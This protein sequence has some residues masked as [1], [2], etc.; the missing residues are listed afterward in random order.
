MFDLNWVNRMLECLFKIT[1]TSSVNILTKHQAVSKIKYLEETEPKE[2]TEEQAL[3]IHDVA[4]YFGMKIY[5][6]ANIVNLGLGELYSYNT[7]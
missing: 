6:K 5:Y 3:Y 2:I 7:K 4:K 1:T